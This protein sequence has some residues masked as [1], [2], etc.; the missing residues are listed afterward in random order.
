M[1]TQLY[2]G[3]TGT[4]SRDVATLQGRRGLLRHLTA[5]PAHVRLLLACGPVGG[6]IFTATY[7]IEGATRPGYDAWQQ[8]ISALSLGPGGWVQSVNFIVFG[9][10]SCLFALGLRAALAP[11]LGATWVPR[12]QAL[13]GLGLILCGFFAQDPAPGYP[14]GA[15]PALTMHGQVHIVASIVTL[16][17]MMP[18]CIVLALRY[19]REPGRRWW[20]PCWVAAA[21]LTCIC[22]TFFGMA[23]AQHGPAGLF[24][25]LAPMPAALLTNVLVVHVWPQA[26][27][28]SPKSVVRD[29]NAVTRP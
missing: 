23:M 14:V 3:T 19:A 21:I 16:T 15:Q 27:R 8:A 2:Q 4:T 6:L 18:A 1:A 29:A 28:I 26:G 12:L 17:V 10:F 25:R 11:G 22:M 20:A 5:S 13:S 24:E 7:L 9:L